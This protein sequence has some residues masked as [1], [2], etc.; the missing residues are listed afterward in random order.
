M[1]SRAFHA[2]SGLPRSGSTLLS[3]ILS[4]NPDITA[5]ISTPIL[6]LINQ[7]R[8]MMSGGE[9]ASQFDDASR[10][11][12]MRGLVKGYYEDARPI[13]FD[14][15]RGWSTQISLLTR[16]F[17]DARV[18]CCV[19]GV[20]DILNSL[21]AAVSANPLRFP[22]I[23]QSEG[24]RSY[25]QYGRVS[26]YMN[27]NHGIVGAA[28]AGL[29]EAWFGPHASTLMVVRYESLVASPGQ[30]ISSIY[31]RL[32]IAPFEHDFSRIAFDQQ[33]YDERIDLPGL[34]TVRPKV[35]KRHLFQHL[36]PDLKEKYEQYDFWQQE[37][38]EARGITLI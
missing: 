16:L 10:Q 26:S 25:T 19:R 11:Q 35:S 30:A 32:G 2:I 38:A 22:A 18:I 24:K 5:G 36:L 20:P 3:A 1:T 31:E 27:L 23:T 14:T 9:L 13:V 8:T 7:L 21:E 4:Q 28:W 33:A 37:D 15:H 34:H 17:G 12:S 29:R 6:P